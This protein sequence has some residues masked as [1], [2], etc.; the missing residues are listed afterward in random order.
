MNA[1]LT[2]PGSA[3]QTPGRGPEGPQP[4]SRAARSDAPVTVTGLV[5]KVV[6]LGLA[7]AIA[8]WGAF[9]LIEAE[10]WGGLALLVATTAGLGYLYLTRRHIPM[11]YL[12]PGTLFL[13]AFQVLPVLI[14]A[15]TAFT[16]FS[17]GHRGTKDEA[18]TAIQTASVVRVADSADYTLSVA[19]K[20]DPGSDPLV[21]LITDPTTGTAYAGDSDGLSPLDPA[22]V[23]VATGGKITAAD[24]YTI[25]NFGQAGARSQ[26]VTDFVVPTEAGAIRAAGLTRAYEGRAV[27]AYDQACDCVRDAETGKVWTA[28]EA[29]GSFVADDGETLAQ[30][31]KVGVGLANFTRV[32]SDPNV[33]GPF[34]STLI[35]NFAFAIG[36]TGGTFLLGMFCALALHHPRM[37]G[38]NLYRILLILPYAMPSFAMLL[39]WRDM[40]NTDF[41]LIN[42]LFGLDVNWLGE[43]WSARLAV[44]MIQL[45]L[46]YPYMFLV[47]TG[48]LQSI[49]KELGEASAVDGANPW[50]RFRKITLPL[51][52][53][54]LSPLLISSF[55]FNFNNFNAIWLTTEGAPFPVDNPTVGATDLLITYTYR[56][57]FGGQ[58]AQ[59]GYAAAISIF[60][61]ALVAT[62]SAIS[63]R[64]TRAQ[65]EV[66]S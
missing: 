4:T 21:F 65:E 37:R 3:P 6:L 25:L 54:S 2:G 47:A 58:G 29:S 44:I 30:G 27:R 12:V 22:D 55:A 13:I 39:I 20:G 45:W 63:F 62:I 52:L 26:E 48:A 24:G 53:I 16:N 64:R 18:I 7:A 41:G 60:I 66:W 5:V 35:W 34:L 43:P 9:P 40:F 36:S 50:Q 17:D 57:A 11:K 32:L 61:F 8:V 14:T 38:T 28:D 15:A 10:A 46:G 42:N 56:L 23:T 59:F 33:S 1:P 51:L 31:W 19:T 49:P